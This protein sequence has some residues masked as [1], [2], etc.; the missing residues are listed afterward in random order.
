MSSGKVHA[1]H[2]V[3]L[4][5]PAAFAINA[6]LCLV[7]AGGA[8]IGCGLLGQ[9][10]SPDL[11][12]Q[13]LTRSE[14]IVLRRLGPL[15]GL[16]VAFWW[17]YAWLIPHRHWASHFPIVGTAGRVAYL[18]ILPA[19]YCWWKCPALSFP[20]LCAQI[21]TGAFIGLCVSDTAHWI[22]DTSMAS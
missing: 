21:L 6:A 3:L 17:P 20:P 18:L 22:A 8:A 4:A 14:W 10:L 9:V 11:D 15:G 16:F 7:A 5:L 19:L 1:K 2:S 13:N 12:Q